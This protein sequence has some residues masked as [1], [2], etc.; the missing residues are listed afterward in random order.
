MLL[1]FL[2]SALAADP[3]QEEEDPAGGEVPAEVPG[4]PAEDGETPA[5]SE[6]GEKGAAEEA[7]SDGADGGEPE[8]V[9]PAVARENL[10]KLWAS[11]TDEVH[12]EKIAALQRV[13]N[14][15]SARE[16]L[17]FLV[18]RDPSPLNRFLLA[19]NFELEEDYGEALP[20]YDALVAEDLSPDLDLDVRF[21][22]AVVMD[23][24][25]REAG[26]EPSLGS[27]ARKEL[28]ALRRHS[29][30]AEGDK[31][32]LGLLIGASEIHQG[33]AR[34]GLR[35]ISRAIRQLDDPSDASWMQARARS[36]LVRELVRNA[37]HLA[38]RGRND[39][40][41]LK[42]RMK[43]MGDAESQVVAIIQLNE[44]EYVLEGLLAV[45]DAYIRLYD[46]LVS[47]P[48]PGELEGSQVALYKE[49]VLE[50]AEFLRKKAR[51]FYHKGVL[52][53]DHLGWKGQSRDLLEQRRDALDEETGG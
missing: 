14:H 32:R 23:D 27:L 47:A 42:K 22:R 11:T 20:R 37:E 10:R 18:E 36:A 44:P 8:A 15:E 34:R 39:D 1:F 48:V 21:R 43:L 12:H 19:K 16:V 46:E 25:S 29:A 49:R 40:A 9:D 5:G 30:L 6:D 28:K 51:G 24:L 26:A 52:Y 4:G 33:R 31:A 53:A 38:I 35:R 45:A 13:G 50:E 2:A 3:V 17:D 41:R 7:A